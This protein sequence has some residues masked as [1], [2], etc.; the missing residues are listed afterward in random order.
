MNGMKK[1]AIISRALYRNGATKA[2]V[3]MLK[4]IDYSQI[5][6]DLWILDFSNPAEE[7]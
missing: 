5:K 2:L 3:E 6:L 1:V 7:L 4:R